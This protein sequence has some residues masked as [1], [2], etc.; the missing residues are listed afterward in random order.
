M[1]QLGALMP[2]RP[3]HPP[4]QPPWQRL[5]RRTLSLLRRSLLQRLQV[6]TWRAFKGLAMYSRHHLLVA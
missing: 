5:R 1:L 2:A 3:L 4:W 6:P